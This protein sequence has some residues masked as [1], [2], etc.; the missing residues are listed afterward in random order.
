M[1]RKDKEVTSKTW[2]EEVLK[3]AEW[4][5]LGL[6]GGDGWPYVVPL[7]FGYGD[8]FLVLH[9]SGLGK[10]AEMLAEN[11]RVCFQAVVGAE[12]IRNENPAN[13]SMR[14]QS[15]SGSGLAQILEGREEKRE[16]L[17]TLMRHYDGPLEPLPDA[18]VD[19]TMVVKVK[20]IEKTGKVSGYPAPER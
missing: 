14:Y 15:V 2:M 9:G 5:E 8:G 3:K 12:V 18:V 20:I 10:K 4:L 11:P 16:A 13:F 19:K 7:N 1:R 17:K 6:S